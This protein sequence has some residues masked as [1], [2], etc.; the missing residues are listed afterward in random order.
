[1]EKPGSPVIPLVPL[2]DELHL[3]DWLAQVKRLSCYSPLISQPTA[4]PCSPLGWGVTSQASLTK[5]LSV[6][7]DS[8]FKKNTNMQTNSSQHLRQLGKEVCMSLEPMQGQR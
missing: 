5:R 1:M 8:P 3:R 4:M 6:T 7:K 2:Q